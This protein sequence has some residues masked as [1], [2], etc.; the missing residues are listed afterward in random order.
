[1][2]VEN[3]VIESSAGEDGIQ[4]PNVVVHAGERVIVEAAPGTNRTQL[5]RALAGLWP[6]GRGRVERPRNEPVLYLPRGAPY[7]PRGT[8]REVLAYP[9]KVTQFRAEVFESAL[10]RLRLRRLVPLLDE[11]HRWDRELAQ[12]EQS[13]VSLARVVVHS[14]PWL[15]MDGTL[16]ALP[17]DLLERVAEAFD[18]ELRYTGVVHIGPVAP[19]VDPLFRRVVHL[20]K[21]LDNGPPPTETTPVLTPEAPHGQ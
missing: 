7:L 19:H 1:V 14:P 9:L 4:E 3:L 13:A 5:F 21:L 16:S 11:V 12:D 18:N 8:L 20:V 10:R 15:L 6:W 2:T 17:D